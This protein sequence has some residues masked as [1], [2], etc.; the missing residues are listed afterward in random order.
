[1]RSPVV[2]CVLFASAAF[3]GL[4][5][6]SA[7]PHRGGAGAGTCFLPVEADSEVCFDFKKVWYM[8]QIGSGF[9]VVYVRDTNAPAA[10]QVWNRGQYQLTMPEFEKLMNSLKAQGLPESCPHS[11]YR[12]PPNQTLSRAEFCKPR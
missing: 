5:A 3:F 4:A 6:Q 10:P 2:S 11:A 9:A 12:R 1:M 7:D 8:T